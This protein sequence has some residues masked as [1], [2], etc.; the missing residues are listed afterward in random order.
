M[1]KANFVLMVLCLFIG[2]IVE[3]MRGNVEITIAL[4]AAI[5]ACVSGIGAW[6][7]ASRTRLAAEGRLF[8]EQMQDYASK[9]M[10]DDL[11]RLYSWDREEVGQ[12]KEQ[13]DAK[14]EQ[15]INNFE[16]K[17]YTCVR[18]RADELDLAR[19]HITHYFLNLLLLRKAGYVGRFFLREFCR[20]VGT[21][22]LDI[23]FALEKALIR[24]LGEKDKKS[25]KEINKSIKKT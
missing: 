22:I 24:Y 2:H 20:S 21:E 15:W 5:G 13:R 4:I 17:K 25:Q 1:N 3:Y 16:E 8:F 10:R 9:E 19:R 6:R 7:S 14:A 12:D 11:R 18:E 23:N